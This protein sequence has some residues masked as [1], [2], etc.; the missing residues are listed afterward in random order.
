MVV[1]VNVSVSVCENE[2]DELLVVVRVSNSV[3]VP[4]FVTEVELVFVGVN[5]GVIVAVC[6]S[7]SLSDSVSVATSVND[8]V[9][10]GSSL[11]LWEKLVVGDAVGRCVIVSFSVIVNVA[12]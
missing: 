8:A 5:G 11:S 2:L 1:D 4:D 12:F 3:R 6:V 9:I 7:S 10:V